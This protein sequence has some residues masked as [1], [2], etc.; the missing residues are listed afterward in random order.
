MSSA[1]GGAEARSG[2]GQV[3]GV[4]SQSTSALRAPPPA[5]D[6]TPID[7]ILE[8]TNFGALYEKSPHLKFTITNIP[9]LSPT[10]FTITQ[11]PYQ[12]RDS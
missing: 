9:P 1:G 8:H 4:F 2:G 10:F 11:N 3:Q 12:Q 7:S 6:T 5:E